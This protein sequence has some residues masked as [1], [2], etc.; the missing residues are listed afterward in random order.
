MSG[1]AER[2][3]K[4]LR[5]LSTDYDDSEA[6]DDWTQQQ[7]KGVR[8]VFRKAQDAHAARNVNAAVAPMT[9]ALRNV[10][11]ATPR[12]AVGGSDSPSAPALPYF[13]HVLLHVR[14]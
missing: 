2:P 10:E 5:R 6:G 9:P 14:S 3:V 4:R 13:I 8:Y 12:E 7:S 1:R 11:I